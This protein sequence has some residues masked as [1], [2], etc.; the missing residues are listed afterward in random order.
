MTKGALAKL[1]AKECGVSINTA[2]EHVLKEVNS[3]LIPDD[4]IEEDGRIPPVKGPRQFQVFGI[5][6]YRLT[7]LGLLIA[8][9]LDEI[10]ID[11]RF[12]IIETY[13]TSF[14]PSNSYEVYMKTQVTHHMQE[15]PEITLQLVKFGVCQF[16]MG[17]INHPFDIFF[18][19][20]DHHI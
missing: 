15:Y 17:R 18:K 6:C 11:K 2:Y 9:S 8:S 19:G 4:V 3:C 1:L 16:L 14:N 7:D 20:K 5:S 12:G 13:F 10:P